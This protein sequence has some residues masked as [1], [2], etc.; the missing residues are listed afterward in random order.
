MFQGKLDWPTDPEG[1]QKV[2]D[3]ANADLSAMP[4]PAQVVST[5]VAGR[6]EEVLGARVTFTVV[7]KAAEWAPR[8]GVSILAPFQPKATE[9]DDSEHQAELRNLLDQIIADQGC[10]EKVSSHIDRILND[11]QQAKVIASA[12]GLRFQAKVESLPQW[13]CWGLVALIHT[14]LD[15]RLRKCKLGDCQ[16]YFLHWPGMRGYAGKP[17]VYCCKSCGDK[18]KTRSYRE[19]KKR[20][21]RSRGIAI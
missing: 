16:K 5:K 3:F 6:D 18:G 20:Q 11:V 8:K 14:E 21:D 19:R 17:K 2:I 12:N 4:E 15:D 10:S 13:Y 7:D 9:S 1:I